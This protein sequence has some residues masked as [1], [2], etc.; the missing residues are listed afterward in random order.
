MPPDRAP[1]PRLWQNLWIRLAVALAFA[2]AS[3]VV[4]AL[5]EIVDR[6]HTSISHVVWVI[7]AYNLAL[8]AGA[9]A[10]LVFARRLSSA[11]A[12]VS[13]LVLF[14]LASIGC[15]AAN[16]LHVLVPLRCVQGVGGALILC[17]SLA[18]FAGSARPGDSALVG[19][20]A[21]AAIGAAVGPA[22][23]GILTQ[24]FSWR[25]IFFAQAPVAAF[26]AIAVLAA[27]PR[28]AAEL[29]VETAG[30]RSSLD[31]LTANIAL[32][33]LSAGLIGALFLVVIELINA[34]LVSPIGAAAV[35]TTIPVATALAERLVR[36][37]SPLVLGAAGAVL[38]AAGLVLLGLVTHRQ[39]GVVVAAL[40]LC[41]AGLGLGFP[42]L[43]TAALRSH[44]VAAAR[45]AKTV[46]A[47]DA[48]LVLG[49]LLLTPVF[50][51]QLNS[52]P[53]QATKTAAGYV[54]IAPIPLTMKGELAIRLEAAVAA[55]PVSRPPDI[56]PVFDKVSATAT[57]SEKAHLA[58]LEQQLNSIIQRAA[59]HAF[60]KPFLYAALFA[61]LV[62]PLLGAR[63]WYARTT[64]RQRVPG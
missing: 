53:N 58:V 3:I 22:A 12:L 56:G 14:G 48:G 8:I 47:R 34:W 49:L 50:V 19:W 40:A 11:R 2:D 25:S 44:G 28:P 54:L 42:G 4:L 64:R 33:L 55:A 24:L 61:L 18:L 46:A 1:S 63:V 10:V 13:G 23:G 27:R 6:L 15:G 43:T 35:V 57:P 21:A 60:K 9:G 45:A 39:L 5:P 62:L 59:T 41:G 29:D 20:S 32:A 37:R 30:E 7:V 52:V 36:G 26:A 51:N 31:P 38:V 16:S 17:S